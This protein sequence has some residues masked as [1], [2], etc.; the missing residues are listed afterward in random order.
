MA[1][2]MDHV[3]RLTGAQQ[4]CEVRSVNSFP[5][6][7]GMASS[8]SGYAALTL[9]AMHAAGHPLPPAE[10]SSLARL[11]SGSAARSI[12]GGFVE[13]PAGKN[14]EPPAAIQIADENFWPLAVLVAITDDAP[15]P[16][17]SRAAMELTQRHSPFYKAWVDA[18]A[19]DLDAMRSAVLRRDF[20]AV[21]AL[22]EHSALKMHGLMMSAR[23]GLLYWNPGT[24]A[25]IQEVLKMRKEGIAV[26]FTIDA[27]PQ[28]KTLCHRQ[29]QDV[30]AERLLS[31]AGVRSL[32]LCGPGPSAHIVEQI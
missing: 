25:V 16:V 13:L 12:L 28:V 6:A 11:G 10:A 29:D 21:G 18:S 26:Y 27:G 1:R 23:P 4:F 14:G 9:A 22:A 32:T 3:R 15:K 8:A 5:T 24:M 7:A 19:H 30:V 20:E 31:L 2:F 17:S